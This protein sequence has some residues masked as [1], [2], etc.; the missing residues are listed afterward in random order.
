MKTRL[1]NVKFKSA[2]LEKVW[3]KL[4]KWDSKIYGLKYENKT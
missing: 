3:N 4:K 1:K 2:R